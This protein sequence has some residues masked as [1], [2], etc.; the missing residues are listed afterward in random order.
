MISLWNITA[1]ASLGV[2]GYSVVIVWRSIIGVFSPFCGPWSND[3]A[4][5]VELWNFTRRAISGHVGRY[6]AIVWASLISARL[7]HTSTVSGALLPNPT[8]PL[9]IT[10]CQ[11]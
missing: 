11:P 8:M 9:S 3:E 10:I 2:L 6:A 7:T 4:R 1:R 5:R